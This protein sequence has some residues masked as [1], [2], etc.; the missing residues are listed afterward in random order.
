MRVCKICKVE[1]TKE[2]SYQS[3]RN[4][5]CKKHYDEYRKGKSHL[6]KKKK[7]ETQLKYNSSE[8]GRKVLAK[9]R[10]KYYYANSVK[11]QARKKLVY[12]VKI[13]KIIKPSM[14][15]Q[16]SLSSTSITGCSG[17]LEAHHYL[18]YKGKH[19][20]DIMWLCKKHHV[21]VHYL[22]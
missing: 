16:G 22:K 6:Y 5:L 13:G 14:C 4:L 3:V 1:L 2:N 7:I 10:S 20:K 21:G 19:W 8:H 12:A 9:I 18:G 15:I 11:E 17:R